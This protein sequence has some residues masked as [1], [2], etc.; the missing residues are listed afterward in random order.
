MDSKGNGDEEDIVVPS[1]SSKKIPNYPG[2]NPNVHY[3]L[4][5]IYCGG[6]LFNNYIFLSYIII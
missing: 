1:A 3:P 4:T 6:K 5:V 2:P